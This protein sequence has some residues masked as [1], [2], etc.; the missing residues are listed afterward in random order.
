MT[1]SIHNSFQEPYQKQWEDVLSTEQALLAQTG[2]CKWD[3]I[4]SCALTAIYTSSPSIAPPSLPKQSLVD[5]PTCKGEI[6]P[7]DRSTREEEIQMRPKL[8]PPSELSSANDSEAAQL[9]AYLECAHK[10]VELR[11][12]YRLLQLRVA[13]GEGEYRK[14]FVKMW[15]EIRDLTAEMA[16][17]AEKIKWANL[18]ISIGLVVSFVAAVVCS[19]YTGGL[20]LFFSGLQGSLTLGQAATGMTGGVFKRKT[21]IQESNLVGVKAQI[22]I[23]DRRTKDYLKESQ[24]SSD[25]RGDLL[26]EVR[27][28]LKNSALKLQ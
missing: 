20:S 19:I 6:A 13:A 5:S 16:K 28:T 22:D 23:C 26:K 2:A 14:E 17:K 7:V 25:V 4:S 18:G 1:T 24:N 11:D 15:G 9:M 27:K 12:A 21:D 8:E 10:L 3:L